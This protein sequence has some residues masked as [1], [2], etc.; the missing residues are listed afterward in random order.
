MVV[1]RR[2]GGWR[3]FPRGNSARRCL[4]IARHG[5]R[6]RIQFEETAWGHIR[7]RV[8]PRR[9]FVHL[10]LRGDVTYAVAAGWDNHVSIADRSRLPPTAIANMQSRYNRLRVAF[11]APRDVVQRVTWCDHTSFVAWISRQDAVLGPFHDDLQ[12]LRQN[13][14]GHQ[15][16]CAT[17]SL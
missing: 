11:A 13:F 10:C 8:T 16:P 14:G 15:C 4:A 5:L 12:F 9:G 17:V 7:L 1:F 6:C 2:I 3:R